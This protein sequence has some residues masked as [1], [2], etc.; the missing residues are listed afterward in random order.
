MSL[1]LPVWKYVWLG[2]CLSDH[3]VSSIAAPQG[4]A[5]SPFLFTLY[6]M[7]FQYSSDFCHLQRL[8]NDLGPLGIGRKENTETLWKGLLSGVQG[9][10][11]TKEIVVDFR[12][13]RTTNSPIT[14]VGQ[15]VELIDTYK[16]LGV[17]L[18]NKLDWRANTEAVYRKGMSS[19]YFLRRL[20]SFNVC[21][22]TK[23]I[24]VQSGSAEDQRFSLDDDTADRVFTI[25]ITDLRTEDG[26]TYW[27]GIQRTKALPDLYTEILLLVKLVETQTTY[28]PPLSTTETSDDSNVSHPTPTIS[29]STSVDSTQLPPSSGFITLYVYVS[30][31]VSGISLI[32]LVLFCTRWKNL[33]TLSDAPS[34][35]IP[36]RDSRRLEER[37]NNENHPPEND[38]SIIINP[39]YQSGNPNTSLSDSVYQSV[40][41]NIQQSDILLKS[42]TPS[43]NQSDPV[44]QSVNPNTKKSKLAKLNVHPNTSQPDSVYQNLNRDTD[45]TDSVYQ[46]M[47][48]KTSQSDSVQQRLDHNTSQ[49]DSVYQSMNPNT[50]QADSVYK[51]TN[52]KTSQSDSIYQS[53][54]PNTSQSDSV[55]QSMN[56]N[57][58]QSDSVYQSLTLTP[59]NQIQSTSV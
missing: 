28:L 24:P 34:S 55:Y 50:S 54:N 1:G 5:L 13:K 40:N 26:G 29:V 58:N 45:Q 15:N 18:D 14:I 25:T 47:N 16:Y 27:C 2:I 44:Y 52:P 41:T 57:T 3:L 51:C 36:Q 30:L 22:R 10:I 9:N 37:T 23:D 7:D 6:M 39:L 17:L 20:R 32:V 12:R 48:P 8:S 11:K 53:M 21:T 59:T 42:V 19:L 46:I 33:N 56:P 31:L 35:I 4:T 43:S 49:S 38:Y